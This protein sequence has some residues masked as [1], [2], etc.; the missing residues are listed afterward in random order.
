MGNGP[1]APASQRSSEPLCHRRPEDVLPDWAP[2]TPLLGHRIRA[3]THGIVTARILA[4]KCRELVPFGT[5]VGTTA[6]DV[7]DVLPL[8]FAKSSSYIL[9]IWIRSGF[10][11]L[12]IMLLKFRTFLSQKQTL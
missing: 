11:L 12:Q 10:L 4:R 9:P 1:A 3:V 6:S 2:G 5:P 8:N 7:L